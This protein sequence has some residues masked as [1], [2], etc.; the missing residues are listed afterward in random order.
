MKVGGAGNGS[1]FQLFFPRPFLPWFDDYEGTNLI[2][3]GW[4]QAKPGQTH[5]GEPGT[6]FQ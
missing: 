1:G 4:N 3:G 6:K 2:L 5:D